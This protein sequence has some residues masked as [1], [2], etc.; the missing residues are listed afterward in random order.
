MSALDIGNWKPTECCPQYAA[1]K[2]R[3]NAKGEYHYLNRFSYFLFSNRLEA[4]RELPSEK[5]KLDIL[6]AIWQRQIH[7]AA[8]AAARGRN[9]KELRTVQE[10]VGEEDSFELNNS[11]V[12]SSSSGSSSSSGMGIKGRVS[13]A[14]SLDSILAGV[15]E[16]ESDS[17]NDCDREK[18]GLKKAGG[19]DPRGI[20]VGDVGDLVVGDHRKGEPGGLDCSAVSFM[21]ESQVGLVGNVRLAEEEDQDQGQPEEKDD[22]CDELRDVSEGLGWGDVSFA[23]IGDED[24]DEHPSLDVDVPLDITG[25]I[26]DDAVAV[27]VGS[28]AV[29]PG[30]PSLTAVEVDDDDTSKHDA[31]V[32]PG[33]EQHAE[34]EE[35]TVD[36]SAVLG[37]ATHT[38][39]ERDGER[40]DAGV[41]ID[42]S[43]PRG[44]DG[45]DTGASPQGEIGADDISAG[46]VSS[47]AASAPTWGEE[48]SVIEMQASSLSMT[49]KEGREQEEERGLVSEAEAAQGE[50]FVAD[51]ESFADDSA[52]AAEEDGDGAN[53]AAVGNR[54]RS[55]VRMLTFSPNKH[56]RVN[57]DVMSQEGEGVHD[58]QS[59][60][61]LSSSPTRT[62]IKLLQST[63]SDAEQHHCTEGTTEEEGQ[64]LEASAALQGA[65]RTGL[66]TGGSNGVTGDDSDRILML[67]RSAMDQRVAEVS[68]DDETNGA[69][70]GR[71]PTESL[72]SLEENRTLASLDENDATSVMS[73]VL[74]VSAMGG[75]VDKE[76]GVVEAHGDK[77]V[78]GDRMV[79]VAGGAMVT[80]PSKAGSFDADRVAAV[81]FVVAVPPATPVTPDDD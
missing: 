40:S 72:E 55:V 4:L 13:V 5:T 42:G 77:D 26:A 18:Y 75:G 78:V 49:T 32:A 76:V 34:Q 69:P 12:I 80:T 45:G 58:G 56:A 63:G 36:V 66:L 1:N 19:G 38:D 33:G 60:A 20:V 57:D 67:S 2:V 21:S 41:V 62:N 74:N 52:I 50:S 54:P 22:R 70:G 9:Q 43:M 53:E 71:S 14:A 51:G 73:S 44:A 31:G 46:G 25:S 37:G 47:S 61:S 8:A 29:E 68:Y 16:S 28:G 64:D 65:R 35:D 10:G 30:R 11:S 24:Y 3:S 81:G 79:G 6:E 27:A 23:A 17:D 15:G 39:V 48:V 7:P 59:Q